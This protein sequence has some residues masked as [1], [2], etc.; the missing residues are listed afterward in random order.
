LCATRAPVT[1]EA[2]DF[3]RRPW[4]FRSEGIAVIRTPVRTRTPSAGRGL[5]AAG[6]SI[7]SSSSDVDTST[8]SC[9]LRQ[10]AAEVWLPIRLST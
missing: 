6:A 8:E 2:V 5:C 7:A 3:C 1:T 9:V 10:T 4:I